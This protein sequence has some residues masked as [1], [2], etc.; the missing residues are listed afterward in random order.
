MKIIEENSDDADAAKDFKNNGDTEA[1][2]NRPVA[3]KRKR[4]R[5]QINNKDDSLQSQLEIEGLEEFQTNID[6]FKA[7]KMDK[8]VLTRLI[9]DWTGKDKRNNIILEEWILSIE[10]ISRLKAENERHLLKEALDVDN[11]SFGHE[12]TIPIK[13]EPKQKIK[14]EILVDD[15]DGIEIVEKIKREK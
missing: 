3:K 1:D 9:K 15:N 7:S 6:D 8:D 12:N 11:F 2:I 4:D 14:S 10:E 13:K 5:I